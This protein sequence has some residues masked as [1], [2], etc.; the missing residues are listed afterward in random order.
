MIKITKN[1]FSV[2]E[3]IRK[4]KKSDV[5]AVVSF[6]GTVRKDNIKQMKIEIYREMAEKTLKKLENN[7]RKRFDVKDI[8]IIHRYGSLNIGDN[9]VLITVS[10]SHRKDAFR[11]CEYLIDGLKKVAPIWKEE[12]KRSKSGIIQ[13]GEG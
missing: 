4:M 2:D 5:G 6:L 10:S 7:A 13:E 1:D 11:A 12:I 3:V 9:I 8:I